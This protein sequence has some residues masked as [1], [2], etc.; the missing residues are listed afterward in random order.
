MKN[1][2]LPS[3]TPSTASVLLMTKTILGGVAVSVPSVL[4]TKAIL[5][6]ARSG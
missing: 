6:C 2:F 5:T 1:A 3:F 4:I